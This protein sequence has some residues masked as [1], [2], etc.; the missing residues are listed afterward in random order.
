VR[1]IIVAVVVSVV[2]ETS[3][4]KVWRVLCLINSAEK[5]VHACK[6]TVQFEIFFRGLRLLGE[7]L[8]SLLLQKLSW[9]AIVVHSSSSNRRKKVQTVQFE[10]YSV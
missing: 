9:R 5:K 3:S 2:S 10:I 6:K 4:S 8:F 1:A 7:I